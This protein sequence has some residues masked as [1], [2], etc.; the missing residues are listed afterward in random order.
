MG[1][2]G[3]EPWENDAAADWFSH[4]L[5]DLFIDKIEKALKL[6]Y[7]KYEEIRAACF[8][9]EKFGYRYI[10][11]YEKL[12]YHINIAIIALRRILNSNILNKNSN[13]IPEISKEIELLEKRRLEIGD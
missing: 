11:P 7:T 9:I 6:D 3:Y 1:S 10:W 13:Y 5:D 12:D 4:L 8:V 2:W